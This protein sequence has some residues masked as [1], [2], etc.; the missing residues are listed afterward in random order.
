MKVSRVKSRSWVFTYD[1]IPEWSLNVH[2]IQGDKYSYVIDTG[3]GA[4]SMAPLREYIKPDKPVVVVNT[5]Y[6]WDHVWGNGVFWDSLIISHRLCRQRL[7]TEWDSMLQANRKYISGG[8]TQC[9]PNLVFEESLYLPEDGIFLFHT[10][11]HTEDSIS[12]LDERDGV[13]NAGDNVGD[14][15]DHIVP[16]LDCDKAVYAAALQKYIAADAD[17]C[18]S[19]HNDVMETDIFKRILEKL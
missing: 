7:E 10:P 3:L 11:G 12:V 15:R 14:D 18:V 6:H 16:E 19:G 13:I 5:H 8:V 17:I 9:L 1:H 2:L 4:C